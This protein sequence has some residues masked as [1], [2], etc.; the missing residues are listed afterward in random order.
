MANGLELRSDWPLFMRPEGIRSLRRMAFEP[1]D[2]ELARMMDDYFN[3]ESTTDPFVMA[4]STVG[5]SR[6]VRKPEATPK[7]LDSPGLGRPFLLVFPTYALACAVSRE[8][9]EDDKSNSLVPL[10][11][12]ELKIAMSETMEEDAANQINDGFDLQGWESDGVPLFSQYHPILRNQ[13]GSMTGLYWSNRHPTDAALSAAA[14]DVAFTDMANMRNDTGRWL[15]A[16]EPVYLHVNPALV[17]YA[18]VLIGTQQIIGSA[19]NDKNL[20]YRRLEVKPNPRLRDPN[21]W[22]L[23]TEKKRTGW[24]WYNRR[25]RDFNV[26]V[27]EISDVTVMMTTARWGRGATHARGWY[28]SRGPA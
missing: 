16:M 25:A 23:S 26:V 7:M 21:A 12:S 5:M 22:F 8:A 13:D 14:L 9:Q 28:A 17:P 24:V 27:D 19:N 10:I 4:F 2:R 15:S 3:V 11:T 18:N 6:A 1:G 20:Y